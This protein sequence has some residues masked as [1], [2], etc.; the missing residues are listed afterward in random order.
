MTRFGSAST[1]S[2]QNLRAKV[3]ITNVTE[4]LIIVVHT[5]YQW[6]PDLH[7]SL[8]RPNGTN[9]YRRRI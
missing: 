5:T 4:V 6:L 1:Q 9:F 2:A 7:H 8:H 3:N